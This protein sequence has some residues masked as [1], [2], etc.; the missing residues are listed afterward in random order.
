MTKLYTKRDMY[1]NDWAG[2]RGI[3]LYT[4]SKVLKTKRLSSLNPFIAN[5]TYDVKGDI[6]KL[7]I[8]FSG[9]TAREPDGE[10]E[11]IILEA[12][13]KFLETAEVGD[14]F[15]WQVDPMSLQYCELVRIK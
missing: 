1:L 6:D 13:E 11:K 7:N 2:D 4:R 15:R 12:G 14:A 3:N 8:K 5:F 9:P 10:N